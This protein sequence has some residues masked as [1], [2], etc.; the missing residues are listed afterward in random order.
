LVKLKAGE[1]VFLKGG[2]K[3]DAYYQLSFVREAEEEEANEE[4]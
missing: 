3:G 2:P 1:E 4:A